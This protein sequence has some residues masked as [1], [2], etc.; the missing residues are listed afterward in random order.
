MTCN[1]IS[2]G[3]L[4]NMKGM[5]A[6]LLV[7][8]LIAAALPTP[9][10]ATWTDKSGS[11]PGTVSKGAVIGVGVGAAVLVGV[12]IYYKIHHKGAT[13]VKLD[14]PPVKFDGTP[15]QPAKQN[16]AVTNLMS[17]P[18][19]V[20]AVTVDGNSGA[21]TIGDAKQVPFTLA[22]GEKFE[23][24]LTLAATN[25]G[26]KGRVRIV[27]TT[28]RLQKDGIKFINVS[29]GHQKSLLRKVIP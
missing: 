20:K 3:F 9:A 28:D 19:T 2:K 17:E 1:R 27:A 6:S 22:P 26:G 21:F 4:Q 23:I 12:F 15:G 24:P 16:V 7:V 11:L 5:V 18:V 29:Y 8:A 25:D 10:H 13:Q 14:A